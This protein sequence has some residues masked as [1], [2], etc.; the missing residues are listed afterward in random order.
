MLHLIFQASANAALLDRI[1]TGD[2]AVFLESGVF[3]VLKRGNSADLIENKLTTNS[4]Y[5]LSEDMV[6]RGIQESQL[7]NGMKI[8]DYYALVN[9]TIKIPLNASWY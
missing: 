5:V 9:L 6:I 3:S 2:V 7:V 8:I 4:I 1:A